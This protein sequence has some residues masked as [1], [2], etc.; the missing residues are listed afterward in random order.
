MQYPNVLF[1]TYKREI[2]TQPEFASTV[3][4]ESKQQIFSKPWM[5]STQRLGSYL[6]ILCNGSL[7]HEIMSWILRDLK[8]LPLKVKANIK[9]YGVGFFFRL[10]SSC[11]S[12]LNAL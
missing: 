7:C 10:L 8:D 4:L 11:I 2:A 1:L 6:T 9:V 12:V 3:C 5:V